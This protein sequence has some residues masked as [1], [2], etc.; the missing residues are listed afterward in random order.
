MHLEFAKSAQS[1]VGVEWE[2]GLVDPITGELR[3][4]SDDILGKLEAPAMSRFK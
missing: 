2:L 4:V 1:T 3:N